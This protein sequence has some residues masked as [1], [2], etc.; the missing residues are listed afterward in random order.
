MRKWQ[1]LLVDDEP[2]VHSITTLVLKQ[3]RWRKRRFKLKSAYSQAEAVEILDQDPEFHVAIVDVVM[4]KDTSGLELCEHIRKVCP[5]SMRIILRTGQP[6]LAPEEQVLNEYDIDYY[7]AKSDATPAKLY[8]IVRACLRSSQDIST[9]LAYGKQLQ[10][11]TRTL[12]DVSSVKDLKVF[13]QEALSFLDL[14]HNATTVF[15]FDLSDR[16]NS[17]IIDDAELEEEDAIDSEAAGKALLAA[18]ERG[19]EMLKAHPGT[20][21]GLSEATFVI[22]FETHEERQDESPSSDTVLGGLVFG[23]EPDY[24]TDKAT[25]DFLAD[26][27]LFLEN[28]CIAFGTLRLRESLAREQLLR[29]QMYYERMESIATMVTGVA[30]ELNTPLGVARTANSMVTELV[31]TLLKDPPEDPEDQEEL[32]DDLRDVCQL[33]MRNLD[34]A[35]KLIKG[36]KQL[37]ASQLTD[38]QV[39]IDLGEILTDCI[40]TMKPD[41]KKQGIRAELHTDESV[42]HDWNGYPGHLSQ[43][44]INLI[45]NTVR[46][47][48]S[49]G[50][51]GKI[52]IYLTRPDLA[53][54][55]HI[56]FIDYG[57][58]VPEEI[59]PR[60][61]DAF[62]TS[63]RAQGGTGLGLAISQ[64]IVVNLLGGTIECQS[65]VGKGT[66][67]VID[68]PAVV[69]IE[70]TKKLSA[71]HHQ[72]KTMSTIPRS[73][74]LHTGGRNDE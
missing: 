74:L 62:V 8:S 63:A 37:S 73:D 72:P 13:M 28:W 6:G 25:R 64:N 27:T 1:I 15:N 51:G 39:V 70:E 46:Y 11:F 59:L 30:H 20:D 7:L 22:P 45:Q 56:E 68:L 47:A 17:F 5:N 36:F 67:F 19:L 33:L 26:A 23:F 43:V 48:Y 2:D 41:L 50:E 52:D 69:E 24:V 16:E 57:K 53:D 44:L 35:Q 55:F 12:Q 31:D 3:K 21:F 18:H 60:L 29:D 9:L 71:R 32:T 54:S 10:S 61:F 65:E 34:R 42:D 38:D 14:K 58:G 66:K 49:G 40:E 4:E